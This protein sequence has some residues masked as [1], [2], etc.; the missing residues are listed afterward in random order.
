MD[1]GRVVAPSPT[2]W[3]NSVNFTELTSVKIAEVNIPCPL[4]GGFFHADCD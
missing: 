1:S 4:G 3:V 2:A